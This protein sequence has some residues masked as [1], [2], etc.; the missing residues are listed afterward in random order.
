MLPNA[1]CFI[2]HYHTIGIEAKDAISK[3]QLDGKQK[4]KKSKRKYAV[5]LL[6]CTTDMNAKTQEVNLQPK[7]R[8]KIAQIPMD[9][10]MLLAV[11]SIQVYNTKVLIFLTYY[12][13]SDHC[14]SD[15]P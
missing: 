15:F 4:G 8:A 2:L 1:C 3:R 9:L 7:D 13:F 12:S 14:I 11:R 6:Y 5:L 10:E